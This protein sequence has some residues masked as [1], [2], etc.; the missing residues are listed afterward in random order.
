MSSGIRIR[1]LCPHS[2]PSVPGSH[3]RQ[4]PPCAVWRRRSPALISLPLVSRI[5]APSLTKVFPCQI[6]H[7]PLAIAAV[8]ILNQASAD[9]LI[10]RPGQPTTTPEA[11][12]VASGLSKRNPVNGQFNPLHLAVWINEK[13]VKYNLG[14]RAR[15]ARCAKL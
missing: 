12:L 10:Y 7:P 13:P 4:T 6:S 11:A 8:D 15:I 14:I 5:Q 3:T 2:R 9:Q 1:P